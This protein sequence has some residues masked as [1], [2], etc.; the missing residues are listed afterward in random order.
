MKLKFEN[1]KKWSWERKVLA[2]SA[3]LAALPL[4]VGLWQPAELVREEPIPIDTHIPRGYVLV[5]IEVQN[6][7]ALDSILGRFGWVDLFKTDTSIDSRPQ[8]LVAKHVR[9][10]RAPQNPSQF[11]VLVPEDQAAKIVAHPGA[12]TVIVKRP[13]EGGTEFVKPVSAPP[14]R[15]IIY[16]GV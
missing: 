9:I 5:P 8:Q 1:F 10:L 6:Y 2:L 14:R 4:F 16:E 12:F 11:A 7:E 3:V 15:K 13:Q